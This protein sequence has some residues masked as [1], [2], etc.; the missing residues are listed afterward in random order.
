MVLNII[1]NG[2]GVDNRAKKL[3]EIFG[4]ASFQSVS[5]SIQRLGHFQFLQKLLAVELEAVEQRILAGKPTPVFEHLKCNCR[6]AP[7]FLTLPS[8]FPP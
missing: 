3:S 5:V 1:E 4:V 8:Y 2:Q 6:F 7:V